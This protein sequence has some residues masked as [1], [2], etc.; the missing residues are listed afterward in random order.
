MTQLLKII[1][2]P[3]WEQ[4]HADYKLYFFL[5]NHKHQQYFCAEARVHLLLDEQLA[6]LDSLHN[7]FF[8]KNSKA[9]SLSRNSW[10]LYLKQSTFFFPL[11]NDTIESR[12]RKTQEST[13]GWWST[14]PSR[15][16]LLLHLALSRV[17]TL[18]S[19][20]AY[21]AGERKNYFIHQTVHN[22][23]C[24]WVP[25]GY[26][27]LEREQKSPRPISLNHSNLCQNH[28]DG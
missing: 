18:L 20:Q 17:V 24:W 27:I 12:H 1:H 7:F 21:V 16:P 4:F 6:N 3:C 26:I 14:Q 2:R 25:S 10:L 22:Q 19:A 8:F 5:P 13:H 9:T 15:T 11:L 23:V 28:V